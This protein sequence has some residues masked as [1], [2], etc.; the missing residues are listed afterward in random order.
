[1]TAWTHRRILFLILFAFPIANALSAASPKIPVLTVCEALSDADKY[2]GKSVI[3]VGRLAST[4]E[5]VWL[6]EDCGLKIV[7]GG[8]EFGAQISTVYFE[9]DFAP[10]LNYRTASSGTSVFCNRN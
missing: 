7:R 8:R 4:D 9:S 10:R 1:M 2:E 3:I 6:T 5:G